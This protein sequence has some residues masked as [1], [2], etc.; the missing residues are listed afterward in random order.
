MSLDHPYLGGRRAM[1]L[2]V[3]FVGTCLLPTLVAGQSSDRVLVT[4]GRENAAGVGAYDMAPAFARPRVPD[5]RPHLGS[6]SVRSRSYSFQEETISGRPSRI[7]GAAIGF[8]I[9]FVVG[10]AAFTAGRCTRFKDPLSGTC[11]PVRSSIAIGGVVGGVAG[12]A[13]GALIAPLWGPSRTAAAG[14]AH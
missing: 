9:G 1:R 2:L 7:K 13:I 5:S 11:T 12:A 3:W 6:T 10:A 4:F 8:G 14:L